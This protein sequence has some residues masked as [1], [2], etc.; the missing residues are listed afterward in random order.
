METADFNNAIIELEKIALQQPTAYMCAEA[1]WWRCHRS[2]VS[3][4]LK[5]KGWTVYHIMG[6]GKMKEHTYT[7]PAEII[8]GKLAYS[9]A[10]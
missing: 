8:N 7:Q 5:W 4:Y 9:E 6:V 1:L 3:D 2:M 10:S